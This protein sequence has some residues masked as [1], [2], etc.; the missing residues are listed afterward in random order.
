MRERKIIMSWNKRK[1][2]LAMLYVA[3]KQ[4]WR[5]DL[6]QLIK[7]LFWADR[8]H[9]Q[10]WGDLITEDT[11]EMWEYGPVPVNAYRLV[12]KLPRYGCMIDPRDLVAESSRGNLTT[13]MI[14]YELAK[15][16]KHELDNAYEMF[17][18]RDFNEM[19]RIAHANNYSNNKEITL[20]ELADGD[21]ELVSYAQAE[22][23][24]KT[25]L[26]Y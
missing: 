24:F 21:P 14:E 26:G 20:K 11:Y 16:E 5:I 9:L 18:G 2:M 4:D 17:Q 13:S 23:E 22:Q 15:S 19:K 6:Y 12:K 1:S 25:A 3:S 7:T 10:R 8:S